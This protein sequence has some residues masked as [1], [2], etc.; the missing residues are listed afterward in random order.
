MRAAIFA[1]SADH[2]K[3]HSG[4]MAEGLKRHGVDVVF[5]Q[6]SPPLCDFV[7]TWGWARAR[8][9]RQPV[10]V[11]E[12]GYLGDRLKVWTSLGWN[13]LNGRAI[14]NKPGD[15]GE[16]AK[17]NFGHLLKD[18]NQRNGYALLLGQ[19]AGD[20]SIA[21][22][23]MTKW[24]DQAK[25]AMRDRGYDVKFRPHPNNRPCRPIEEDFA[26]A[27]CA[28]TYNSNSGVLAV[29]AGI[30]TI[31]CDIGSMA[32]PVAAHGLEADLTRPD[33][34]DWI[35]ALSWKQWTVEEIASGLAWEHVRTVRP[36]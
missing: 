36:M 19:V 18:W 16:R 2:H 8:S 31:A 33:R 3:A 35:T 20:Q 7:V 4:P 27:A 6:G 17:V 14:W 9:I 1:G 10:L 5:Y 12:R 26:G 21:G 15:D 28:V 24:Y 29:L 22:V 30:P 34:R 32:W 11:M 23:N 25:R 13:G